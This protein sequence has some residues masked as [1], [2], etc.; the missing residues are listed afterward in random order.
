[1]C[2]EVRGQLTGVGGQTQV[3]SLSGN[4]LYPLSHLTLL[5]FSLDSIGTGLGSDPVVE[6]VC[7]KLKVPPLALQTWVSCRAV[8]CC[9]PSTLEAEAE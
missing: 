2:V 4:W 3:V 5:C 1:M 9:S 8:W 6:L 7:A